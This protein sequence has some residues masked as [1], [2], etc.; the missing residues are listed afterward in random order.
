MA[1]RR[2]APLASARRAELS[3]AIAERGSASVQELAEAYGVSTD[4]IRR[5][6]DALA[7]SGVV[8]RAHGGAV[9]RQTEDLVTPV[10]DRMYSEAA[11]KGRIATAAV[12]MLGNDE[13][14]IVNGGSTTLLFVKSIPRSLYPAIITNSIPI[15]DQIGAGTF[16]NVIA[17]GGQYMSELKVTIGPLDHIAGARVSVDTAIIGVRGLH[18]TRG[19]ST[20]TVAEA[21]MI[22]QMMELASRTIVLAD[23]SKFGKSAFANIASLDKIDVLVTND[24]PPAELAEALA[25]AGVRTVVAS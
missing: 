2:G 4:T 19:I 10:G 25:A 1:K 17:I 20:A 15:L 5:D 11:A 18:A 16:T 9:R 12:G 24:Q 7:D 8:T 6:L 21:E 22:A 3:Q 13:T 14:L 23:S